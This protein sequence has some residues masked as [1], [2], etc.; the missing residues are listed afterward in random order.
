MMTQHEDTAGVHLLRNL[1]P[2]SAA[3]LAGIGIA[4]IGDLRA[5]GPVEAFR[6]LR[7]EGARPSL[8]LLW[9]MAAGL[10]GRDWRALQPAEKRALKDALAR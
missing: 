3:M 6:R 4:T 9:A 8:I 2:Q 10:Q 5:I 1:G 7:F